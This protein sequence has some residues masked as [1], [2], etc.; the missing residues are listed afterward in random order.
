MRRRCNRG[1]RPSGRYPPQSSCLSRCSP[2]PLGS[3]V[4]SHSDERPDSYLDPIFIDT[5]PSR[6]SWQVCWKAKSAGASIG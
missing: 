4:L 6:P 1:D 5:M 3:I 2:G